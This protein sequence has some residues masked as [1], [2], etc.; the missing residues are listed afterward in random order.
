[1][2]KSKILAATLVSTALLATPAF[3]IQKLNYTGE[4]LSVGSVSSL[5]VSDGGVVTV[6]SGGSG[7]VVIS[8]GADRVTLSKSGSTLKIGCKKPCR[9][10]V[11]RLV[12]VTLPG[13]N[14]VSVNGGGTVNV[15]PGF[16]PRGDFTASVRRGGNIN[17]SSVPAANVDAKVTGGGTIRVNASDTLKATVIGAGKI[18]YSGNPSITYVGNAEGNVEKR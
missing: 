18:Y 3:A 17:A 4:T 13:L 15:Q 14:S 6:R 12:T 8:E 2:S 16:S 5:E 10:N 9:G 1:M 11:R 7:A